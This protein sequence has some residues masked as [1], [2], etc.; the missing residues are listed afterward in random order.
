MR[1]VAT[2]R[3]ARIIS[4]ARDS[5]EEALVATYTQRPSL[6]RPE[7]MGKLTS[8]AWIGRVVALQGLLRLISKMSLQMQKV[9]V[10]PWEL[11]RE[12]REF[13]DK[14]VLMEAALR[15]DQRRRTLGE[16]QYLPIPF[17]RLFSLTSTKSL[18]L[19]SN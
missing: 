17:R 15:I 8:A 2:E 1:V 18:I 6:K 4:R 3:A 9:N 14:I 16:V 12:Q 19:K 5:V 13:F 7:V 10:I 11:M